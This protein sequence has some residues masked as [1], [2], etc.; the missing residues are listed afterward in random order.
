M[1]RRAQAAME[2]MMQYGWLF[3]IVAAGI[4]AMAYFGVFSPKDMVVSSCSFGAGIGCKDYKATSTTVVL[5][6]QNAFPDEIIAAQI[7]FSDGVSSCTPSIDPEGGATW[8]SAC[9]NTTCTFNLTSGTVVNGNKFGVF[10]FSNCN[11]MQKSV[12]FD[13]DLH[14]TTKGQTVS[15]QVIGHASLRL[16]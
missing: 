12:V 2:F 14:Y 5:T 11:P 4:S 16:E 7:D 3:L 13:M 15:N 1:A 10:T 8:T 9:T 6:I